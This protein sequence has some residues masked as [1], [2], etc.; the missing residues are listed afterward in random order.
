MA[1]K[2][3]S[4]YSKAKYP[5]AYADTFVIATA[6]DRNVTIVTCVTGDPGMKNVE[7]IVEILVWILAGF[8]LVLAVVLVLVIRRPSSS[9]DLKQASEH[10]LTLAEQRLQLAAQAG[11]ADLDTKKQLIDQTFFQRTESVSSCRKCSVMSLRSCR[12]RYK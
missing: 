11:A 5:L 3:K 7:S 6:I 8:I 12:H 9:V 1:A 10:L 2:I 4:T